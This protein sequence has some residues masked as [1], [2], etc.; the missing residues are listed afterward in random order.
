MTNSIICVNIIL[1][2]S[3]KKNLNQKHKKLLTI[4]FILSVISIFASTIVI[5]LLGGLTVFNISKYSYIHFLFIPIP[6]ISLIL[7]IVYRKEVDTS[8]RNI[9]MGII[10]ILLLTL[11]GFNST[12]YKFEDYSKFL[13][14]KDE[15]NIELP[16]KGDLM[17]F[18]N[19][20]MKYLYTK[21]NKEDN[22]KLYNEIKSSGDFMDSEDLKSSLT[23]F[24]NPIFTSNNKNNYFMIYNK[25]TNEYNKLPSESGEYLIYS[26]IYSYEDRTLELDIYTYKYVS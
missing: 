21:F 25:T 16:D 4:F 15:L 17:I 19:D 2:E 3:M 6:L 14:Y 18:G 24:I 10:I 13:E 20:N 7:G 11:M 9:I 12:E 8:I 5:S 22:E 23:I 26:V 1:G